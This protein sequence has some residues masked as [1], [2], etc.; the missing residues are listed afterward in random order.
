MPARACACRLHEATGGASYKKGTGVNKG[1][2]WSGLTLPDHALLAG[3][4]LE[5]RALGHA[6]PCKAFVHGER[7]L[8]AGA[9][10]GCDLSAP[11]K[12]HRMSKMLSLRGACT[13][14]RDTTSRLEGLRVVCLQCL[15]HSVP[16]LIS[17]TCMPHHV[18]PC[19]TSH[20][21]RAAAGRALCISPHA[22]QWQADL[23]T[24][25]LYAFV[26]IRCF[27]ACRCGRTTQ[28]PASKICPGGFHSVL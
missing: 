5:H 4:S 1:P 15:R 3:H 21:G 20:A 9:A 23:R 25:H 2:G 18:Q 27:E 6:G 8:D 22:G 24:H 13:Y 10:S 19:S 17:G 12:P 16:E 7:R 14:S 11:Q 28:E 26:M